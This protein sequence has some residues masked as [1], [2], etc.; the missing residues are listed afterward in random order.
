[1]TAG[2]V[3]FVGVLLF[4]VACFLASSC[5]VTVHNLSATDRYRGIVGGE[6]ELLADCYIFQFAGDS[7]QVTYIGAVGE[8]ALNYGIGDEIRGPARRSLVGKQVGACNILDI[9]PK[10]ARIKLARIERHL[11]VDHDQYHFLVE[12]LDPQSIK[13]GVLDAFWLVA[14]QYPPDGFDERIVVR[15]GQMEGQ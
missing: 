11:S 8:D 9:V 10:G 6:Y 5:Q 15:L 4:V 3:L 12:L 1:M 2:K 7:R 14:R 13:Y